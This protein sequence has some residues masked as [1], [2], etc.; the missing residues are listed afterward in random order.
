[1]QRLWRGEHIGLGSGIQGEYT[2][3]SYLPVP[4]SPTPQDSP[5]LKV[6]SVACC[7]DGMATA[8]PS[9]QLIFGCCIHGP[10]WRQLHPIYVAFPPPSRTELALAPSQRPI[11]GCCI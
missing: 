3:P 6:S 4:P 9:Q 8:A 7:M 1:M 2:E 5:S 10:S 11:F